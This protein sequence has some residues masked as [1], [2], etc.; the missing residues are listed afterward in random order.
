[1]IRCA[2]YTAPVSDTSQNNS[3]DA[4]PSLRKQP[5][6]KA[7]GAGR[8]EV[9]KRL[10]IP[11]TINYACIALGVTAV[12]LVVRGLTL[13]G[14]T[15]Q[16]NAL[17]IKANNSAG[18]KKKVPYTPSQVADDLHKFRQGQLLQSVVI[19]LALVLLLFAYRRVRTA[20]GSRWAMLIV[21]LFTL[22]PIY[23]LPVKG[24]PVTTNIAGVIVGV[25]SIAA[26]A[27][28]FVP[29]P[30][31]QYFRACRDALV[32]PELRGQARPGLFGP[33]RQRPGLAGPG[34]RA[35]AA[36]AA[37]TRPAAERPERTG[38]ASKARSKVRADADAV[39]HGAELARS[40][41]KASKSRRTTD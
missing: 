21:M 7:T 24:F 13:L 20:S 28:V 37:Q 19:A 10:P 34:G 39:A 6:T 8:T 1:M 2:T 14:S 5:Q 12:G 17:M 4:R 25:G 29:K 40:R 11:A 26:L 35:A 31:Q 41:A 3:S 36:Q 16:L 9:P 15:S 38:G 23:A 27:L 22:L 18:S 30:S 32:P 33:R